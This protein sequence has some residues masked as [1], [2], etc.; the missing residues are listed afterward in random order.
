MTAFIIRNDF[1]DSEAAAV[2]GRSGIVSKNQVASIRKRL[3]GV[4]G[5]DCD[6]ILN[7]RGPQK[8][9]IYVDPNRNVRVTAS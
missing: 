7:E 9:R 5:C 3:C 4:E 2:P 1:H 6:G 8:Y